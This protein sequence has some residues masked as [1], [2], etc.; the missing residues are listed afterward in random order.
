MS[1]AADALRA[2]WAPN[3]ECD[4][5]EI[6]LDLEEELAEILRTP[7][8]SSVDELADARLSA[9]LHAKALDE[10]RRDLARAEKRIAVLERAASRVDVLE[11]HNRRLQE[12]LDEVRR[13]RDTLRCELWRKR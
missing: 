2:L 12:D 13:S 5:E 3:V 1:A 8:P 11:T 7:A 6:D 4:A 10:A 9:L